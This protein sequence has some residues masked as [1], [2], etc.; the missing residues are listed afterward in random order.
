MTRTAAIVALA[1]SA[2]DTD[3][4]L[5]EQRDDAHQG[6]R[7]DLLSLAAAL[8]RLGVLAPNIS[9]QDA[10]DVIYAVAC[11]ASVYLRLTRECGWTEAR[12]ADLIAR[13]LNA[14]L[15]NRP[16]STASPSSPE[17]RPR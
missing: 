9:E 2:A 4:Q 12:Y 13:T 7:D 15:A 14:T 11:D 16:T 6:T 1:E 3:P 10:A 5:A 17:K 8:N